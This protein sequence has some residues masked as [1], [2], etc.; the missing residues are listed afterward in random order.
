MEMFNSKHNQKWPKLEIFSPRHL[1]KWPKWKFL[2]LSLI[3]NGPLRKYL[4]PNKKKIA[5]IGIL[6]KKKSIIALNGNC[7]QSHE[8][9]WP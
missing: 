7:S 4:A 5:L 9:K 1:Q 3:K 2:M 8:Q 6:A